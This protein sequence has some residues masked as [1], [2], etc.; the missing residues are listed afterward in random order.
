[1]KIRQDFN[2]KKDIEIL[3][4][5]YYGNHLSDAE[6]ERALKL[7]YLLDKELKVRIK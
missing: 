5:L 2:P 4:A 3:K 7:V 1:M 6:K